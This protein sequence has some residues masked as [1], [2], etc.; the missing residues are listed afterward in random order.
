MDLNTDDVFLWQNKVLTQIVDELAKKFYQLP[1]QLTE[2][3]ESPYQWYIA[4]CKLS[5]SDHPTGF[6]P[7]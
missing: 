4:L 5:S 3:H 2:M 6:P 1:Q 7:N